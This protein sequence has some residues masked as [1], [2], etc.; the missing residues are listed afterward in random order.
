MNGGLI[1]AGMNMS[2]RFAKAQVAI[3]VSVLW[4]VLSGNC[5]FADKRIALAPSAQQHLQLSTKAAQSGARAA[6]AAA[7]AEL[8][9][10][11]AGGSSCE[12]QQGQLEAILQKGGEGSGLEELRSFS[13][14]VTCERLGPAVVAAIDRFNAEAA[15][16]S[17]AVANSLELVRAAQVELA[18]LGCFDGKIDGSLTTTEDALVRYRSSHGQK[19][20]SPDITEALVADLAKETDLVCPMSCRNGEVSKGD[21]CIANASPS[22]AITATRREDA[23]EASPGRQSEP[24]HGQ[25]NRSKAAEATPHSSSGSHSGGAGANSMVGVGF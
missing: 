8:E 2:S 15:A 6:A 1:K 3:A 24:L 4:L 23:H 14:T 18:R 12:D 17:G 10:E 5:A 13:R 16:H 7:A 11:A 22:E 21:T 25:P 9:A 19:M 20:T